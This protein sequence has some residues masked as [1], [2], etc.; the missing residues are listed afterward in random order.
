MPPTA[1][2]YDYVATG[3]RAIRVSWG[4]TS[5]RISAYSD[6]LLNTHA[7]GGALPEDRHTLTATEAVALQGLVGDVWV[8][9]YANNGRTV[10]GWT[11]LT[12]K[13]LPQCTEKL[14]VVTPPPTVEP[15]IFVTETVNDVIAITQPDGSVK[16]YAASWTDI[17]EYK[18][19]A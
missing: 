19:V 11:A 4:A 5:A 14:F 9:L 6:F 17:H 1:N 16:K 3:N 2:Y 10:V 13:G 18:P 15:S 7:Q 12:H 8:K